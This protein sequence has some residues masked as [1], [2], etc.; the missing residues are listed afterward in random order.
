[1][2]LITLTILLKIILTTIHCKSLSSSL[3]PVFENLLNQHKTLKG[4][5]IVVIHTAIPNSKK[6]LSSKFKV[7]IAGLIRDFE[8]VIP[9]NCWDMSNDRYCRLVLRTRLFQKTHL[10][11]KEEKAVVFIHYG[12]VI[13][14]LSMLIKNIV[15]M[16]TKS[17]NV[18]KILMIHLKINRYENYKK[19][20]IESFKPHPYSLLN[21]DFVEVNLI[22]VP[23]LSLKAKG[24]V[25]KL[26][27]HQYYPFTKHYKSQMLSDK[28]RW[29]PEKLKNFCGFPIVGGVSRSH[30]NPM[31]FSINTDKRG[32][33]TYSGLE[34]KRF[35]L[36]ARSLN[37]TP[38]ISEV[39]NLNAFMTYD[40]YVVAQ[41]LLQ[42]NPN[43]HK[44]SYTKIDKVTTKIF[45]VPI[46]MDYFVSFDAEKCLFLLLIVLV[47]VAI[48]LVA[49]IIMKLDRQTW[50]S[51]SIC[52]SLV[53][54]N[55]SRSPVSTTEITLFYCLFLV[56]FY[57][58]GEFV[59]KIIETLSVVQVERK[60]LNYE[61]L[62]D[63]NMSFYLLKSNLEHAQH[64]K[65]NI[66]KNI[67]PRLKVIEK[68]D[69]EQVLAIMCHHR[70]ISSVLDSVYISHMYKFL[71]RENQPTVRLTDLVLMSVLRTRVLGYL[72][73]PFYHRFSDIL[74]RLDEYGWE[75]RY[76]SL[77]LK[78][79]ERLVQND[80]TKMQKDDEAN[81]KRNNAEETPDK[82]IVTST[83]LFFIL[84]AGDL[85]ALLSLLIENRHKLIYK[86]QIL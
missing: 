73:S 82:N 63:T 6:K 81:G 80:L 28:V 5:N 54:A 10:L 41:L 77:C 44:L 36:M 62:L 38:R 25:F 37:F 31:A 76:N 58:G 74:W 61:D 26:R 2:K 59:F 68:N 42:Y 12:P 57:F 14:S 71:T 34:Y 27:L 79:K 15:M 72:I 47:I 1:M 30:R 22:K 56:C 69:V 19:F 40:I 32:R 45:T 51:V 23:S 11:A 66:L 8:S 13:P 84:F 49:S 67:V 55:H 17:S 4:I 64:D 52:S 43:E 48:F 78:I 9:V 46:K 75:L 53:G 33:K 7:Y 39:R 70:N 60:I 3:K 65:T 83:K 86:L 21:V 85:F 35:L 20:L 16:M 50:N 18:P 24:V 29:F